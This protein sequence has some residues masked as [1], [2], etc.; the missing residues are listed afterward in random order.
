MADFVA[1][2]VGGTVLW[3]PRQCVLSY[4]QV[5]AAV[6]R[7]YDW[8]VPGVKIYVIPLATAAMPGAWP[9]CL[10]KHLI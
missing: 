2:L 6:P 8:V 10:A 7:H 4:G 1:W 3:R 5:V 9:D